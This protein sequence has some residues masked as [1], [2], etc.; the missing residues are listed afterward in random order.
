MTPVPAQQYAGGF[1]K[2]GA[3]VASLKRE[4][5]DHTYRV[6]FAADGAHQPLKVAPQDGQAARV[7]HE[8]SPAATGMAAGAGSSGA[9]IA[10]SGRAT[11]TG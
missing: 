1:K 10:D 2:K 8:S 3:Q 9:G 6:N 5:A 7:E 4:R 11:A